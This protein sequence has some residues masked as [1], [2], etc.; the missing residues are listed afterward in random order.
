MQNDFYSQD[1]VFRK[2][3]LNNQKQLL[4]PSMH[5]FNPSRARQT[6]SAQLT[7]D[8]QATQGFIVRPLSKTTKNKKKTPA[9]VINPGLEMC[10]FTVLWRL[11]QISQIQLQG[12]PR[13][14]RLK[15]YNNKASEMAL[16]RKGVYS[17][18]G[19]PEFSP[20]NPHDWKERMDSQKLFSDLHTYA[21]VT[22]THLHIHKQKKNLI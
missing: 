21:A 16:P 7:R 4:L 17:Q 11:R 10:I 20:Q 8:F 9:V 12:H 3:D 6:R 5:T 2:R 14:N 15:N 13:L 18:G 19:Q 1:I 22:C